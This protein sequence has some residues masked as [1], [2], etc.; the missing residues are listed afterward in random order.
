MKLE[1]SND[2]LNEVLAALQLSVVLQLNAQR[3]A[4]ALG[5]IQAAVQAAS[6]PPSTSEQ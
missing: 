2:T 5:A 3:A 6:A 4:N 1:L